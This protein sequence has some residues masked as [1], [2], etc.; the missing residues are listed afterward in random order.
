MN[1]EDINTY[2]SVDDVPILMTVD[3]IRKLFRIS[4][5]TAYKY[6]RESGIP[7]YKVGNQ[8]RLMR[9]DVLHHIQKEK[10]IGS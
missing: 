5:S 2:I 8:I 6:V 3:D 7:T 10:Q 1:R 9:D 4:R